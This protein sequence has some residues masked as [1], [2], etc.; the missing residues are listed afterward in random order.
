M[1]KVIAHRGASGL[2]DVENT[3]ESFELAINLGCDMVEFDIRK[4]M[5]NVL[6]VIHD[7]DFEGIP[8]KEQTYQEMEAKAKEKGYHIPLVEEVLKLCKGR[9]FMDIEVKETGYE[10]RLVKLF[11]KYLDYN[12]YSVKS[13]E[14]PVPYKIKLLDPNITTGLLLGYNEDTFQRRFNEIFPGR[15]LKAC[16][17]DFVSPYWMLMRFGFLFRMRHAGYPVYVWTVNKKKRMKKLIKKKG[18]TGIISDRPDI[19]IDVLKNSN[20]A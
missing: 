14:D 12:E 7:P 11:K 18:L 13:F 3:L 19:L 5:D 17:A 2:A 16:N 20:D 4:T 10:F 1:V 15:R 6:I 9:I 8:V